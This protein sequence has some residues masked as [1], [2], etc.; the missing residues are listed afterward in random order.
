MSRRLAVIG[1]IGFALAGLAYA[2]TMRAPTRVA[3]PEILALLARGAHWSEIGKPFRAA[4]VYL[5]VTRRD[6]AEAV[7]WIALAQIALA[8]GQASNAQLAAEHAL[9]LRPGDAD[10][11]GMRQRALALPP[12]PSL[13]PGRPRAV[14]R[15][16]CAVARNLFE[17]G[18]VEDAV[19]LLQAAAWLD[20]GAARPYR[21][22]ANM[23]Y[24]QGDVS[25]AV[26]AQR[27]AVARAP[28]SVPLRRN[29]V[30]L[31]SALGPAPAARAD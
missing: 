22:L 30:A 7:A 29:L 8:A 12:P 19:L 3:S 6:P 13:R 18:H 31:E 23:Y 27:A 25:D 9:A 24:L 28:Q 10:I 26:V 11:E 14:T 2:A 15:R 20:E 4:R 21:D 16:R 17:R 5:R 1:L